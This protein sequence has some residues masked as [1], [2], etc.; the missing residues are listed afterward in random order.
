MRVRWMMCA[1]LLLGAAPAGA[2]EAGPL[3]ALD[4]MHGCWRGPVSAQVDI[5]ETW[6][7]ADADAMLATTRYLQ[8]DSVVGWEFSRIHASAEDIVLTP[9]PEGVA[10]ASFR[11]A[12]SSPGVA[13]FI[14]PDNDFPRS[15]RYRAE[16]PDVLLVRLQG[17]AQTMEWRMQAGACAEPHPHPDPAPPSP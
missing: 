16:G 3:A 5:E 9:Y 2:R 10:R 8:S 11:L 7:A 1:P 4:F 17:D 12:A 6:T 13:E 14:N 15:I